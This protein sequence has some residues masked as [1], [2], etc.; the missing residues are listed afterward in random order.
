MAEYRFRVHGSVAD[1]DF[2]EGN[3][4][5][6]L[7]VGQE[8]LVDVLSSDASEW[9]EVW[10]H[11]DWPDQVKRTIDIFKMLVGLPRDSVQNYVVAMACEPSDVLVVHTL[12]HLAGLTVPLP[13]IPLFE[14]LEDL[15]R[16]PSTMERLWSIDKYRELIRIADDSG[17]VAARQGIHLGYSDSAKDAGRLLAA[18]AIFRVQVRARRKPIPSL[19]F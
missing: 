9:R 10:A 17:I 1:V 11:H 12:Q 13:V 4:R 5:M 19:T 18:W 3:P 15:E 16:A 8:L 6:G 7:E 2:A 14:L